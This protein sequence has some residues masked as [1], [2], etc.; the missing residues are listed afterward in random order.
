MG[1]AG[2]GGAVVKV[3]GLVAP[4]IR[5][6]SAGDPH[7]GRRVV[8]P[9]A[10]QPPADRAVAGGQLF[11]CALDLDPHRAAVTGSLDHPARLLY[12]GERCQGRPGGAPSN[13][14]DRSMR[15]EHPSCGSGDPRRP[16]FEGGPSGLRFRRGPR[17]APEERRVCHRND[18]TSRIRT[19]PISAKAPSSKWLPGKWERDARARDLLPGTV[20]EV[21]TPNE[22]AGCS[23]VR[24]FPGAVLRVRAGGWWG[25]LGGDPPSRR[26]RRSRPAHPGPSCPAAR[27]GGRDRRPAAPHV[28]TEPRSTRGGAPSRGGGRRASGPRRVSALVPLPRVAGATGDEPRASAPRREGAPEASRPRPARAGQAPGCR[29]RSSGAGPACSGAAVLPVRASGASA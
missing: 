3:D 11:R 8:G 24:W 25:R 19:A 20:E 1:D 28:A 26:W 2:A 4:A 23:V 6:G 18:G 7:L 16:R 12:R 10:P 27:A 15:R 17:P 29:A 21:P 14:G 22:N 9:Q 13:S 5:R